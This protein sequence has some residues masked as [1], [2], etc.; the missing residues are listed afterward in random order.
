MPHDLKEGQF[1]I[2]LL[3]CE[4]DNIEALKFIHFLEQELK[5]RV[6]YIGENFVYKR[7]QFETLEEAIKRS[8]Y[9]F[10]FVTDTMINDKWTKFK[11]DAALA[12]SIQTNGEFV[13][14]VRAENCKVPFSLQP[15]TALRIYHIIDDLPDHPMFADP[16]ESNRSIELTSN[17]A[18]QIP[19]VK[20]QIVKLV[21]AK[22]RLKKRRLQMDE[23]KKQQWKDQEKIRIYEETIQKQMEQDMRWKDQTKQIQEI[24]Q[25]A[26][27]NV[28][29]KIASQEAEKIREMER[30]RILASQGA[31]QDD[32]AK[33][34]QLLQQLGQ[35]GV[36][37][38]LMKLQ[39]QSVLGNPSVHYHLP[40]GINPSEL[41]PRPE[42]N[43]QISQV[44]KFQLGDQNQMVQ[45]TAIPPN[46]ITPVLPGDVAS[47]NK[48]H[49]MCYSSAVEEVTGR[50]VP[51]AESPS[52]APP[53]QYGR[54]YQEAPIVL[55]R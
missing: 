25:R 20:N 3:F 50:P 10:I 2:F 22:E 38:N 12:E 29:E 15:L 42:I 9:T 47:H 44:D 39:F 7:N 51:V 17:A 21:G 16:P 35:T 27:L 11:H 1:D 53:H 18:K 14:P 23:E 19:F 55:G 30:M 32:F 28:E 24:Y 5:L 13:I 8:L 48:P 54:S 26:R 43:L 41:A 37:E 6:C 45:E 40:A 46:Q 4:D 52:L 34:L 36:A 31:V 49:E 33:T